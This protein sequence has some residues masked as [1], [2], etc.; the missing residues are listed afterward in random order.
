M[1]EGFKRLVKYLRA[2]DKESM[3]SKG[4][5]GSNPS[6]SQ[7]QRARLWEAGLCPRNKL[8]RAN[9]TECWRWCDRSYKEDGTQHHK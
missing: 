9:L 7:S 4:E 8:D 3:N 6:P 1:I 2:R 5:G